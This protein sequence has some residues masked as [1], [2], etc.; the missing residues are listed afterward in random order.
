M[1]AASA[2]CSW[3]H[4]CRFRLSRIRSPNSFSSYES[5]TTHS[6]GNDDYESTDDDTHLREFCLRSFAPGAGKGTVSRGSALR[7]CA[8]RLK[9][10]PL[11]PP[12]LAGQAGLQGFLH[13]LSDRRIGVYTGAGALLR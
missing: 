8:R 9:P 7:L 10:L 12:D 11:R 1:L 4:W 2:R 3:V 13:L 6:R 5:V